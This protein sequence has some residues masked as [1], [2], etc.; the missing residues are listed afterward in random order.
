MSNL[1][2]A[3]KMV[4]M[5]VSICRFSLLF[6]QSSVGKS[7]V[8]VALLLAR[9]I[10]RMKHKRLYMKRSLPIGGYDYIY[11]VLCRLFI[12]ILFVITFIYKSF[13]NPPIISTWVDN[14]RLS[15]F[16]RHI[17]GFKLNFCSVNNCSLV[18]FFNI[19]YKQIECCCIFRNCSLAW[20][21][22]KQESP[23]FR[24]TFPISPFSGFWTI[25]FFLQKCFFRKS[26]LVLQDCWQIDIV[27]SPKSRLPICFK[28]SLFWNPFSIFRTGFFSLF[29]FLFCTWS[30]ISWIINNLFHYFSI[31]L[32]SISK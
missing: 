29:R 7:N 6:F 3:R 5:Y 4:I 30:V 24:I 22:I 19:I 1:P 2:R 32:Y 15:V 14:S 10:F 12:S 26:L 20:L 9:S 23:I 21:I 31:R 17:S 11:I 16:I 27:Y 8:C 28:Y 25:D 13:W 18:N